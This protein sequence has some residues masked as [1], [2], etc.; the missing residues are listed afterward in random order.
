[1]NSVVP[2]SEDT[3]LHRSVLVE[4]IGESGYQSLPLHR[5]CWKSKYVTGDVTVGIVDKIP[6]EGVQMLLG[7][8]LDRWT[9]VL[10]CVKSV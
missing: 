4:C 2:L 9:C 10:C 3:D 5:V 8:D 6:I 1:M 7:N